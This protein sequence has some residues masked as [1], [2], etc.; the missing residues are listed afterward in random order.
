M[1]SAA[2]Q[3]PKRQVAGFAQRSPFNEPHF[4]SSSQTALRH[5]VALLQPVPLGSPHL[6]SGLQT[7]LRHTAAE[8]QLRPFGWPH[9]SSLA[10]Q[11]PLTQ[12]RAATASVQVLS[13]GL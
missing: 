11:A 8:A 12:T 7:P 5:T 6:P 10:S 3:N 9:W 2:T 1:P 13:I 4:P